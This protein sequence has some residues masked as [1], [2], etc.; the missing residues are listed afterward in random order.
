MS[1]LQRKR[2][3]MLLLWNT[4]AFAALFLVVYSKSSTRKSACK[5]EKEVPVNLFLCTLSL[6]FD[7]FVIKH[8]NSDNHYITDSK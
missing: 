5:Q 2:D 8:T 7:G 4:G 1:T 6:M 3:I